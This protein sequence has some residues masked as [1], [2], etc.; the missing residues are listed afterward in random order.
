MPPLD[1]PKSG[2]FHMKTGHTRNM[3]KWGAIITAAN[4]L[5]H[6]L[7]QAAAERISPPPERELIRA[8]LKEQR[9]KEGR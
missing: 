1:E 2:V 4:T 3:V 6:P 5:L 9:E 8:L 7:L